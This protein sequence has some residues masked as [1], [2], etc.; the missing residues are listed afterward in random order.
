M[1]GQEIGKV[2]RKRLIRDVIGHLE[3]FPRQ[4]AALENA[5]AAFGDDFDLS[6][7]KKA[8]DTVADMDAYNRVQALE[9]AVGRVQNFVADLALSGVALAELPSKPPARDDSKAKPVF[10]ALREANVIDGEICR[11]LEKAQKA[12]SRLEHDY[13][14]LPAGDVHRSAVLVHETARDFI[15]PFREWI[16]PYLD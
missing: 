13:L 1:S 5:M 2:D 15:G 7:F 11:R 8:F 12:R 6:R 4:Y 14:R 16:E 9:K 3:D 10:E